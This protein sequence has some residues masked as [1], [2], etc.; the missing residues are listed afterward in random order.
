MSSFNPGGAASASTSVT[1][2][3]LYSVLTRPSIVSV[4]V[5]IVRSQILKLFARAAASAAPRRTTVHLNRHAHNASATRIPRQRG[6]LPAPHLNVV[7][8]T[9]ASHRKNGSARCMFG[10]NRVAPRSR[11]T[12]LHQPALHQ[13]IQTVVDR[14]HR[15]LR[16][17]ALGPQ[18]HL[19]RRRMVPFAA[20]APRKRAD[21][22]GVDRKPRI[23]RRAL[24]GS[25]TDVRPRA[26]Q[27]SRESTRPG[28]RQSTFGIILNSRSP[29]PPAAHP[30]SADPSLAPPL[31]AHVP[32]APAP[33]R[34]AKQVNP[35]RMNR[36]V[37]AH[38]KGRMP[39]RRPFPDR[40]T[41]SPA[42]PRDCA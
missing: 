29:N 13:R 31:L 21:A 28:P 14:G 22:A 40:V 33:A 41:G 42:V 30:P 1:K 11:L 38:C 39:L 7:N 17:L 24:I 27:S 36:G 23:A 12:C 18:K 19:L 5:L 10:Q 4:A 35:A 37:L 32:P 6:L 34:G 15:D 3:Y 9:A 16:H 26:I 2:P 25:I 8:P 20:P